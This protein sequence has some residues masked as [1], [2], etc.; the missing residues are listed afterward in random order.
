MT[1]G[2]ILVAGII[3]LLAVVAI[4]VLVRDRA[5]GRSSCGCNCKSCSKCS[6]SNVTIDEGDG[7]RDGNRRGSPRQTSSQP[8]SRYILSALD[9]TASWPHP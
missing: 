8:F 3:A 2:T 9:D 4:C 6:S 1:A 7:S 5:N